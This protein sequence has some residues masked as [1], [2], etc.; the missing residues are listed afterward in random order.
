MAVKGELE[1]LVTNHNLLIS[2]G[3]I[4]EAAKIKE[5]ISGYLSQK[6]MMPRLY[7]GIRDKF[8]EFLF[9]AESNFNRFREIINYKHLTQLEFFYPEFFPEFVKELNQS[10]EKM[11]ETNNQLYSGLL[12]ASSINTSREILVKVIEFFLKNKNYTD[13]EILFGRLEETRSMKMNLHVQ[14]GAVKEYPLIADREKAE[15]IGKLIFEAYSNETAELEKNML[16]GS[17]RNAYR[18]AGILT[19]HLPELA[20]ITDSGM[21]STSTQY[22]RELVQQADIDSTDELVAFLEKFKKNPAI[23]RFASENAEM[24]ESYMNG[25]DVREEL[26]RLIRNLL[27]KTRFD[28]VNLLS[29]TLEGITSFSPVFKDHLSSLK[30]NG[31]FVQAIEMAEK[32]QLKEEITEDLKLEA[33]RKLM[34]DFCKNPIKTSLQRLVKFSSKFKINVQN[35]PQI[36]DSVIQQLEGIEKVNPEI[37]YDMERLY[38]VLHIEKKE[39]VSSSGVKV[40]KMLEPVIWFFSMIFKL[41]LKL[42]SVVISRPAEV[43][44]R[45]TAKAAKAVAKGRP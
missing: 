37:G 13:L 38:Q 43:A 41:F 25:P 40:G 1:G 34:D 31:F 19:A 33:F 27:G 45:S 14:G 10:A 16:N 17:Y 6:D 12:A 8:E 32:L 35:H 39:I 7:R 28:E 26:G 29:Q 22:F 11:F 30:E 3:S 15:K 4:D 20:L 44:V 24:L 23:M 2:R 9:C 21:A 36:A 5:L 42:I 18:L